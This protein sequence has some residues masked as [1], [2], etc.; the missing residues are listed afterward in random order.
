VEA[1]VAAVSAG[2]NNEIRANIIHSGTG[3]LS[4]SDI[5]LLAATGETAYAISFNQPVEGAISQLARAAGLQILDHNIIYKVTDDVKEK[6]SAELPPLVTQR[7]LGEAELGKIF[8]ITTKKGKVKIAGCKINNG[9]ISRSH[10]IRVLRDGETVYTGKLDSLKNVKKD[11]MEMRKGSECG[12]GFSDWE[13]F[14][15]GDQIQTYEEE[16]TLRKLY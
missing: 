12:M 7:V 4:E 13:D 15:E 16:K 1:L 3:L 2:G 11:V 5:R 8:E 9:L 10:K 14:Q 6:L